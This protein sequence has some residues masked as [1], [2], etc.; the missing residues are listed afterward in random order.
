MSNDIT[1]PLTPQASLA[2][3]RSLIAQGFYI[4]PIKAG[5]K[6][7][8]VVKDN[9]DRNASK[10]PIQIRKWVAEF[11]RN[12]GGPNWGI[13]L[14]K[15]NLFVADVDTKVGKI[16]QRTYDML[17]DFYGWPETYTVRSPSGGFHKYYNGEHV[18]ALG[19][20]GLGAD[21][22]CPN[23]VVAAG[24]TF[25]QP[26]GNIVRYEA[27]DPTV[28]RAK[29]PP[30]IYEVIKSSK[31][32]TRVENAGDNVVELDQSV[33]WAINFLQYDAEPSIVGKNGDQTTYNT[34]CMLSDYGVSQQKAE[35]LMAEFYNPRCEPPWEIEGL[36]KKIDNA[37]IYRNSQGGSKTAEAEFAN[38]DDTETLATLPTNT[39]AEETMREIRAEVAV[40]AT[41]KKNNKADKLTALEVGNK[42]VFVGG[43]NRWV[44]LADTDQM[45]GNDQ[46]ENMYRPAV[47]STNYAKNLLAS[48]LIKKY[49]VIGYRPDKP[50]DNSREF[51]LYRPSDV[52]P[53]EGDL[54]WWN[55]HID[56][57][58]KDNPEDGVHVLNWMAWRVQN[59]ALKP[60]HALILQGPVPG[61]GKTFLAK[62]L[63][64]IIGQHNVAIVSQKDLSS[65][66]NGFA[67]GVQLIVI[68]EIRSLEK[69][70][71]KEALHELISENRTRI[72]MKGIE[73]KE[74]DNCFGIFAMSNSDVAVS[75]DNNDRR[76]AI[77]RTDAQVRYGYGT[78]KSVDYYN[79][80]YDR[81]DDPA[82][83]AAVA[84][85]LKN[86]PLGK[87]SAQGPAPMTAA[88]QAMAV[89]GLSDLEHWLLDNKI[90]WPLNCTVCAPS[91]IVELL[92]RKYQHN[93][94]AT[95]LVCEALARH[96]KGKPLKRVSCGLDRADN[97]QRSL[98]QINAGVTPAQA[99]SND[100]LRVVYNREKQDAHRA[101]T[102]QQARIVAA[103]FASADA[104]DN[105]SLVPSVDGYDPAA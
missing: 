76:Y 6:F 28:P 49:E 9:L 10:D 56:Y 41:K 53:A 83:V 105:A 15:S 36:N 39:A 12:N 84:Y 86:R 31:K 21:V 88:K 61:T 94:R 69:L 81:L 58:F 73:Q 102:P 37:Y 71:I 43:L 38:V 92:P 65:D 44:M 34:A 85:M 75:L 17:G 18:F 60:K 46:I 67:K 5:A 104:E 98:W 1:E 40:Q 29:A 80:L 79:A 25:T 20:Y 3:G 30:W 64:K 66:F 87:Y 13:A 33:D 8:P 11:S 68:E 95:G 48:G 74:F 27:I 82:S 103:E 55:D 14:K 47:K 35:E 101:M 16:G 50:R 45:W 93:T 26:D 100:Q 70:K 2:L 59:P 63:S 22:D 42:F 78:P 99:K 19:K 23:Y 77:T 57:L 54:A 32:K 72:N 4:F 24:C 89:A 62:M 52:V 96:F 90:M 91:D 7:P 97:K 51:N